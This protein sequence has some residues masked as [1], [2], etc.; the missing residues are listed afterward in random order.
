MRRRYLISIFLLAA[1]WGS[2]FM[3]I[4]IGIQSINPAVF[5]S[6][7]FLIGSAYLF[8]IIK[9]RKINLRI[10]KQ[11]FIIVLLAAIFDTFLPQILISNGERTVA[12]GI[13]SIILSSSPIF[14][15]ILA[16]FLLKDEKITLY[17]MFFVIT[18][19]VGVLI[20]FL[21]EL[22]S[23]SNGFLVSGLVLIVLA[24][25]SYGFG[26]ILL[27]KLG[28]RIDSIKSCF[29]LVFTSFLFSVPTS[30][31]SNGY[32][33]TNFTLQSTLSLI[34]VG[35]ALQ[36]FGYN[37]FFESIKRF[38]A[39]KASY[40]GYL[41]PLFGVIYGSIFLKESIAINVLIGGLLIILSAYFIEKGK[42][43]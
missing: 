3:F 26:V 14:T 35:I 31:I 33:K 19:F 28:D 7:R 37:F 30:I 40:V 42:I 5:V 9:L 39:G 11:D 43:S 13:T 10:K 36:G 41:V 1:L 15:F 4:K 18:G 34:F 20:I 29:L 32:S 8:L 24:S 2:D 6:L 27:K 25:I 21:K 17:K 38:G 16:H 22:Y 23:G 12:S